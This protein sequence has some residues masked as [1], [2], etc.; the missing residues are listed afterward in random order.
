[1]KKKADTCKGGM[2]HPSRE[3]KCWGNHHLVDEGHWCYITDANS[4]QGMR[5]IT[6]R[7]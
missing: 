3:L 4:K 2:K 6:W 5:K 1:M 7:D